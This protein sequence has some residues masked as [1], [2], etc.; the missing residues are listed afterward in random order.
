MLFE[1]GIRPNKIEDEEELEKL[2]SYNISLT[3]S[4]LKEASTEDTCPNLSFKK[5]CSIMCLDDRQPTEASSTY[6][7][8]HNTPPTKEAKLDLFKDLSS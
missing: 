5:L 2:Q 7:S 8:K 1:A 3:P 6:S 4:L